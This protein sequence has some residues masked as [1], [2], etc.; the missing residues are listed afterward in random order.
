MPRRRRHDG[1]LRAEH[2]AILRH[3]LLLDQAG[4]WEGSPL[5]R[6]TR[7]RTC[8]DREGE[9]EER[10]KDARIGAEAGGFG[11]R[12]GDPTPAIC[13]FGW[14]EEEGRG[15]KEEA[16]GAGREDKAERS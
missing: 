13:G 5:Q 15:W 8:C 3:G 14:I 16:G 6:A 7:A 9:E 2:N 12:I 11:D 4:G 10:W 1:V